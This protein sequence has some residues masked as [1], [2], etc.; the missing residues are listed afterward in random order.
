M[1]NW[2]G[3]S[4]LALVIT[5]TTVSAVSAQTLRTARSGGE[6]SGGGNDLV[7]QFV[8]LSNFILTHYPGT[9]EQ[10]SLLKKSLH[11]TKIISTSTLR[12]PK[13][14]KP[15]TNQEKLIAWGSP[16]LIQLK[17]NTGKLYE[18]SWENVVLSRRPVFHHIVHELYRASG[19]LSEDG[20]S[21]D[22]SYQISITQLMLDKV[23]YPSTFIG[24]FKSGFDACYDEAN[25][26]N[27]SD[28]GKIAICS[29][30]T[31]SFEK[32]FKNALMANYN[33]AGAIS[34]CGNADKRQ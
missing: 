9:T 8:A 7:G 22:D 19:V 10:K 26:L 34:V 3:L 1:R 2:I 6:G 14:G 12:S 16:G 20:R 27:F 30:A 17:E 24:K 25:K 23:D 5:F 28:A 21:P 29:G 18:D 32:C 11:Q 31:D 4:K 33:N 13:T 15:I